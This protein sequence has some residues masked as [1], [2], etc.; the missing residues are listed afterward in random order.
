MTRCGCPPLIPLRRAAAGTYPF[1]LLAEGVR[2]PRAF[3]SGEWASTRATARAGDAT[4]TPEP[5]GDPACHYLCVLADAD[6]ERRRSPPE[7]NPREPV[8]QGA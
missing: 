2:G 3:P 7:P 4:S 8:L 5:P 1:G 6:Q